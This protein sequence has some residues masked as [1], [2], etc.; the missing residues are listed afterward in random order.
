MG[1]MHPSAG[2]VAEAPSP[3]I[4][5]AVPATSSVVIPPP[6]WGARVASMV[7]MGL[8]CT[9]ILAALAVSGLIPLGWLLGEEEVGTTTLPEGLKVELVSLSPPTLAVPAD[10]REA[11]GMV[12]RGTER[13]AT[14]VAPKPGQGAPLVLPGS[15]ALDPTRLLRIRARFAP[16]EVVE[17]GKSLPEP[18]RGGSVEHELRSGDRVQKD[19]ILGVFYSV[20]V[21]SKKN[22]LYDALVQLKLDEEIL[23]RS[24]KARGSVPEIF[25]LNARRNVLG[26]RNAIVRAENTL[27]TWKIPEKEI[28]AV[29]KEA[30]DA[31]LEALKAEK[32]KDKDKKTRDREREKLKQEQLKRWARVEMRAPDDALIIERNVALHEIVVD[33]TTNLFVLARVDRLA[34]IANAPEDYSTKLQSLPFERQRWTVRTAGAP[35]ETGIKGRIDEISYLIDPNTHSLLVKGFIDNI[36]N[37]DGTWRLRGGQYVSVTVNMDPPKNVVAIPMSAVVDD[38]KQC[39]V[40]VK[41]TTDKAGRPLKEPRYVLRRVL[42]AARFPDKAFVYSKLTDAQRAVKPEDRD[43]GVRTPEPLTAQDQVITAGVLE[44]KKEL[45]DREAAEAEKKHREQIDARAH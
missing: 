13:V 43:Q 38:G 2:T 8:I 27:R 26:D 36:K 12:K 35:D 6:T 37:A 21:G 22:D 18:G 24:E 1:D 20:D 31:D 19:A 28:Q 44:L 30:E 16:A 39:V 10:V 14:P 17:I 34:V 40:F 29:R 15:T 11:L 41:Q 32:D 5:H 42:L 4:H 9:L 33:P 25:I 3:S 23:E 7:M 45:E